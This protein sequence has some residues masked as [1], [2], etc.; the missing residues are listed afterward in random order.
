[1]SE[2]NAI[3]ENKEDSNQAFTPT[4]IEKVSI[5]QVDTFFLTKVVVDKKNG[6]LAHTSLH[7][8][9]E[10]VLP[11][12]FFTIDSKP[13]YIFLI[14]LN[15]F[16]PI[17]QAGEIRASKILAYKKVK[18]ESDV[19]ALQNPL[20]LKIVTFKEIAGDDLIAYTECDRDWTLQWESLQI[21]SIMDVM[22]GILLDIAQVIVD[23]DS[24]K[25]ENSALDPDLYADAFLAG[26]STL[27][28]DH[29]KRFYIENN[30]I[31]YP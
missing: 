27:D 15:N 26:L 6:R 18:M 8:G 22:D 11:V 3:H 25:S 24:K 4:K 9:Y 12:T 28:S 30:I 13:E 10:D 23:S 20:T 1:M 5:Y 2:N 29:A 14:V 19:F 7:D 31:I 17:Y 16:M 21:I